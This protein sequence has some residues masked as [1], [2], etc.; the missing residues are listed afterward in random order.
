MAEGT[1]IEPSLVAAR[2]H[3][4]RPLA[5]GRGVLAFALLAALSL[6]N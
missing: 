1:G 3:Q 4:P 2:R 6:P 5:T